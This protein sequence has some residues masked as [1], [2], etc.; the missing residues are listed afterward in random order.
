MA[1]ETQT[2]TQTQESQGG[3][4]SDDT[5]KQ[6]ADKGL[7]ERV[8]AVAASGGV[9]A[10]ESLEAARA[11]V[12][13]PHTVEGRLASTKETGRTVDGGGDQERVVIV[14]H[15]TFRGQVDGGSYTL[16]ARKGDRIKV[17]QA[18]AARG[19]ALVALA[20]AK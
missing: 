11:K 5:A 18:E 20:P 15:Y 10:A 16:S 8:P 14:D 7:N 4:P 6:L 19:E 2:D 3:E 12:L 13:A 9:V 17:S 1:R